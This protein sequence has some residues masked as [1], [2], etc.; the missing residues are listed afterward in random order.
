MSGSEKGASMD[1][2]LMFKGYNEPV[3]IQAPPADQVGELPKGTTE[4]RTIWKLGGQH[5]VWSLPKTAGRRQ[6]PQSLATEGS[7]SCGRPAQV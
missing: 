2:A 4:L 7:T 1:A 6:V 3:S 5:V